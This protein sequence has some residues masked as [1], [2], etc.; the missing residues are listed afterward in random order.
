LLQP[1][2]R[3]SHEFTQ[4]RLSAAQDGPFAH[5]GR[6]LLRHVWGD[7][8]VVGTF[9]FF[10]LH[11][12]PESGSKATSPYNDCT[13]LSP[14]SVN[15]PCVDRVSRARSHSDNAPLGEQQENHD[16][17]V[18]TNETYVLNMDT[19]PVWEKIEFEDGPDGRLNLLQAHFTLPAFLPLLLQNVGVLKD[20]FLLQVEAHSRVPRRRSCPH[21]WRARR[22][23][24]TLRRRVGF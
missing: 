1:D 9:F 13:L 15:L 18:I 23:E 14:S 7:D 22:S 17:I 24:Q 19:A 11:P 4:C 10:L 20:L 21:F 3:Q 16:E 2:P 8:N 12:V 6:S 5:H